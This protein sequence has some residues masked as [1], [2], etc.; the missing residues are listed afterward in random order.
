MHN[1]IVGVPSAFKDSMN[2]PKHVMVKLSGQTLSPVFKKELCRSNPTAD[3]SGK[4]DDAVAGVLLALRTKWSAA[5]A[6][7]VGFVPDDTGSQKRSREADELE[8]V[9]QAVKRPSALRY[10]SVS[11]GTVPNSVKSGHTQD[12]EHMN[13]VTLCSPSILK[14]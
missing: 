14:E 2:A 9:A 12:S 7:A 4:E 11:A 5:P 8:P 1:E 13:L 6:P 10:A 3:A